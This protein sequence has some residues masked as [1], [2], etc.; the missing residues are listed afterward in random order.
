MTTVNSNAHCATCSKGKAILKCEGCMQTFCYNHVIDHR[1]ELNKQ[2][3]DVEVTCDLI[4]D[5]LSKQTTN[6]QKHPLMQKINEW[7]HD[8]IEKIRQTA[9][10]ARQLLIKHTVGRIAEIDVKLNNVTNQIRQSRQENDF[11]ETDLRQW[12]EN[13]TKIQ[14]ELHHKPST[15]TVR[16]DSTPLVTKIYV[17][18]VDDFITPIK[19]NQSDLIYTK[20]IHFLVP[21]LP[22]SHL[23]NR[24]RWTQN[25]IT[26]AGGNGSGNEINQLYNPLSVCVDDD[27]QTVYIADYWN[28]RIVE[29][30]SGALSGQT[31]V[32]G[33][34]QRNQTDQLNCPGDVIVDKKTDSLIICDIGNRQVVQW[35]RRNGTEGKT[36]ISDIDCWGL[37]MDTHGYIYVSDYNKHEVKRWRIGDKNGKVVAGS[38]GQ[39]NGLDQLNYPTYIFVDS[40]QS[41]YVSDRYNH[42]V[43]KWKLG[44][45][46]GIIVAGNQTEGNS[47]KQLSY[48]TGIVIDQLGTV[49]VA[50]SNNHRIVRWQKEAIQGSIVVGGNG[51]G[52]QSNQLYNPWG[53][54][55][56]RQGNIYVADNANHRIQKFNIDSNLIL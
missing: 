23:Y 8:S 19:S 54:S 33:T 16:E 20:K 24:S 7:E 11:F 9:E 37:A 56:D 27:N 47:L 2:L 29:W 34:I 13:L 12:K 10:E 46:E 26:F 43:M 53:L 40:E 30:K 22:I 52:E 18:L 28:N 32:S 35:P 50:D 14:E 25:G 41:V 49:Y 39:G 48:P 15:I 1:Q 21:Q 3:E 6:S 5:T 4:Q 42:R 17:D 45:K 36:I 44:A 55:F 31:V 51:H 38:N